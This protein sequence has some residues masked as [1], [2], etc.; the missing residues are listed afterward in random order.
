MRTEDYASGCRQLS[1]GVL[2]C[3]S[4]IV[5][6]SNLQELK[7]QM[8]DNILVINCSRFLFFAG[9]NTS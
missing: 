6:T 8:L 7:A 5:V 4:W 9:S 1:E 2:L 3:K